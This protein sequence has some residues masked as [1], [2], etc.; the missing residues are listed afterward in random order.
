M[1]EDDARP[2]YLVLEDGNV[3][4]GKSFG[5]QK[6]IDGEIGEFF[7]FFNFIYVLHDL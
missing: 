2:C 6:S 3:L 5:A 7:I 1:T 4:Q